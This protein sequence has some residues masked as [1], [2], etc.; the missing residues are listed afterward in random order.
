MSTGTP[1]P[2]QVIGKANLSALRISE[3]TEDGQIEW[4]D[5]V[6]RLKS[7]AGLVED[8]DVANKLNV[9]VSTFSEFRHGN[10]K[11]PSLA[12][13]R[14][15]HFLG[16]ESLAEAIDLLARE[17]NAE[18]LRRKSLRQS[19]KSLLKGIPTDE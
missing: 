17:D 13:L 4:L 1:P 3:L 15:L 9:P 10:G 12:K 18:K 19:R 5:A 14:V 11:L 16:V 7:L 6:E 8:K 2:G